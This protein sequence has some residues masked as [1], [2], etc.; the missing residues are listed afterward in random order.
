[1]GG[2]ALARLMSNQ[3]V[4]PAPSVW[5]RPAKKSCKARERLQ[6]E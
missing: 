5:P 4:Y 2:G 1:M 6:L 3:A